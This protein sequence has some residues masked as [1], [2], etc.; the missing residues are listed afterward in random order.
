MRPELAVILSVD[1]L[2]L[3]DLDFRLPGD[4]VV[5]RQNGAIQ[6]FQLALVRAGDHLPLR[7][8]RG[9]LWPVRCQVHVHAFPDSVPGEHGAARRLSGVVLLIADQQALGVLHLFVQLDQPGGRVEDAV[10][11]L[12]PRHPAARVVPLLEAGSIRRRVGDDKSVRVIVALLKVLPHIQRPVVHAAERV[13]RPVELRPDLR[14]VLLPAILKVSQ[15]VVEVCLPRVLHRAEVELRV[16]SN[17]RIC[18]LLVRETFGV[19]LQIVQRLTHDGVAHDRR[20]HR[21]VGR[22]DLRWLIPA[23]FRDVGH[24]KGTGA[25][26]HEPAVPVLPGVFDQ[27]FQ[28][29]LLLCDERSE[30]E[31]SGVLEFRQKLSLAFLFCPSGIDWSKAIP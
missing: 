2:D 17:R 27:R 31:R 28:E 6:R 11:R 16:Q 12:L 25:G 10:L 19:D 4:L 26:F 30:E 14:D 15:D 1:A 18:Q 23:L 22:L 13:V 21:Y 9:L 29:L 5:S 8:S 7:E 3:H 20:E 24:G